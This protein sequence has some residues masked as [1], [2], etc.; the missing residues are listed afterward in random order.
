MNESPAPSSPR[1]RGETAR[2]GVPHRRG[3]LVDYSAN[4]AASI[5]RMGSKGE[6][7][8]PEWSRRR[9]KAVRPAPARRRGPGETEAAA[10]RIMLAILCAP[11]QWVELRIFDQYLVSVRGSKTAVESPRRPVAVAA[12]AVRRPS[13]YPPTTC[14]SCDRRR[15]HR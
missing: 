7:A 4:D 5:H 9:I 12:R 3:L 2:P 14:R 13:D 11:A 6:L 8:E 1:A 15:C 10:S